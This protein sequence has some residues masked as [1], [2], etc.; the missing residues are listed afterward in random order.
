M[1][2]AWELWSEQ[3]GA[4]WLVRDHAA[5]ELVPPDA[6]VVFARELEGMRALA[7]ADLA[8]V[9]DV[10]RVWPGARVVSEAA[11][12]KLRERA[13]KKGPRVRSH[14]TRGPGLACTPP[15]SGGEDDATPVL[16]L[17]QAGQ[18]PRPG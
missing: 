3:H 2:D 13:Q 10:K 15:A 6:L 8:A 5:L 18:A 9:L 4:L 12:E 17:A 16:P 14:R 11:V 1:I 7:A